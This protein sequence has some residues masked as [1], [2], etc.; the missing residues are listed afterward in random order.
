V[1]EL[2]VRPPAAHEGRDEYTVGR[3]LRETAYHTVVY[4]IGS[5]GQALL[6][7]GLLAVY[8]RHLQPD[9]FG[10]LSLVTI[11]GTIAAAVFY[12]GASSALTRYY[13]EWP[14]PA[15]RRSV[16]GTALTLTAGGAAV[17]VAA[18]LLLAGALSRALFGT[19]QYAPELTIGITSTAITSVAALLLVVLRCERRSRAVVL[20]N[21]VSLLV[22]GGTVVLLVAIWD[23]GV[24]GALIG[25]LAGQIVSLVILLWI[26]RRFLVLRWSRADV[27]AQLRFGLPNVVSG[28][29]YYALDTADRIFIEK[30]GTL[31]DVGVYSL[32]YRIGILI[33]AGFVFPFAQI[34]A[35]MRMQYG[36]QPES[37]HLFRVILTY[38]V[39]T[40]LTLIAALLVVLPN[41]LPWLAGRPSYDGAARVVP[42]VL[43]G[44]L[45]YGAI[46]IVDYGVYRANRVEYHAYLFAGALVL[47]AGLNMLLVP[48]VGFM[49]AAYATLVSYLVVAGVM[50]YLS[51]RFYPVQYEWG[52]LVGA[53]A[54][55]IGAFA[56]MSLVPRPDLFGLAIR[57]GI[58]A[59]LVAGWF[60]W[61]LS[62]DERGVIRRFA[63]RLF[64]RVH[65]AAKP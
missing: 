21:L 50:V 32:G 49:G 8:T 44:H 37:R 53:L 35:P 24:I 57:F 10:V 63:A 12:F 18:G 25:T 3:R 64:A 23:W 58:A 51:R 6:N 54:A 2:E 62:P 56:L 52:R 1:A 36:D 31:H 11:A 46:N 34:W 20:V 13:F 59:T 60:V 42:F 27:R 28:V 16:I 29:L 55:G 17:Q 15:R 65:P 22:A 7:F 38:Y 9:E 26:C 47:N 19:P 14:D 45:A 41:A 48:R 61:T 39:L 33:Q 30:L 40:G 43:L 4:G 5:A